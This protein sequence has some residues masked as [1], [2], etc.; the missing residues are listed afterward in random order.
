MSIVNS[1][2]KNV[3]KDAEL[4]FQ[5]YN[6]Y[7]SSNYNMVISARKGLHT[8]I[9]YDILVLSGLEKIQ[10]ADI[11][12]ISLKTI[13]R[14][15]QSNKVLDMTTSEQALKIMA[16]LKKG[17]EIFGDLEVLRNWLSKP[18]FGLGM[19]TPFQLMETSLGIDLISEE[20]MRIEYGATA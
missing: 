1:N 17:L 15:T 18:Q 5:P 2:S 20:L 7:F 9:F 4:Y 19:Q 10:L 13:T 6:P 8:K 14:Y 11:F 16:L 3:V 12:H